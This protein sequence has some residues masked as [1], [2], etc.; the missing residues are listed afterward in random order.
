MGSHAALPA[1]LRRGGARLRVARAR[2]GG[3]AGGAAGARG[4]QPVPP[5]RRCAL[6]ALLPGQRAGAGAGGSAEPAVRLPLP[7]RRAA[8]D[9][10]RA[11]SARPLRD[12]RR[13]GLRGLRPRRGVRGGPDHPVR[14]L[15][16]DGGELRMPDLGAADRTRGGRGPALPRRP[17]AVGGAAAR[18]GGGAPAGHRH[19]W[20]SPTSAWTAS[21]DGSSSPRSGS[22]APSPSSTT[23]SPTP[24]RR[25][26]RRGRCSSAR[27]PPRWRC[28]RSRAASPAPSSW[29]GS[30]RR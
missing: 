18:R 21:P 5:P 4:I 24:T 7:R 23:G 6:A 20:R 25:R 3:G 17:G 9:R 15:G 30:G 11:A 12:R 10:L 2:P 14:I 19:R 27:S 13:P 29:S 8:R 1:L 26:P 16:A 28:T 22:S